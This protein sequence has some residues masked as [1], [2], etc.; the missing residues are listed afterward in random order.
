MLGL[1]R[2]RV[3]NQLLRCTNFAVA[4]L[5]IR[6]AEKKIACERHGVAELAAEKIADRNPELLADDVEAGEL[7]RRME[8][9]PVV[10]QAG[11]RIADCEA[12]RLELEYIVSAQ[13]GQ[14]AG[15]RLLD[16]FAAAAEFPQSQI[17]IGS[18]DF[19]DGPHKAAPVRA[20]AVQQR[21]FERDGDGGR[22]ERGDRGLGHGV[23]Q[24][25]YVPVYQSPNRIG[26]TT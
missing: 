23:T 3:R 4:R 24:V 20:V 21:G 10:V 11:G 17:A 12:H 15:D 8:L 7:D 16:A 26:I 25:E 1:Q 6:V 13:V 19:D 22:A 9:R 2:L 14:Q 5:R 18:L